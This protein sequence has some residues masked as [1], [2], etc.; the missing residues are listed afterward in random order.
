MRYVF[1]FTFLLGF[2]T[3]I[4]GNAQELMLYVLNR[5][6]D[7]IMATPI[8]A[9]NDSLSVKFDQNLLSAYDFVIDPLSSNLYWTN[10]ISHQIIKTEIGVVEPSQ[11]FDAT[12]STPVDLE[13]DLTNKKIYWADNLRQQIFRSNLDGTEQETLPVDS[14]ANLSAIA[15]YPAQN[16]LFYAGLDSSTIW[17][18]NLDGTDSNIFI[19]K[20]LTTPVRLLIDTIQQKLWQL[21]PF[22]PKSNILVKF[23]MF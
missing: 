9:L 18:S 20:E 16:K 7:N 11:S 21:Y 15:L 2:W 14:I 17:V 6:G 13:V 4:P 12:V 10:T 3:P 1:V 19:N 23:K 5:G 22:T 8:G